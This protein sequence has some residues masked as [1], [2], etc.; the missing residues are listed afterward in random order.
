MCL[1]WNLI[2]LIGDKPLPYY[3]VQI[4]LINSILYRTARVDTLRWKKKHLGE[5]VLWF[6]HFKTNWMNAC[7]DSIGHSSWPDKTMLQTITEHQELLWWQLCRHWRLS[8]RQSH[9]AP[10][11]IKL[12]PS[13]LSGYS[14]LTG[15][16]WQCHAHNGTNRA[17]LKIAQSYNGVNHP[18]GHSGTKTARYRE[19][20]VLFI[21]NTWNRHLIARP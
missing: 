8:S 10:V 11:A 20:V 7:Y 1:S 3:S 12:V 19:N 16:T 9:V 2:Y 6:Y 21:T 4:K 17:T 15:S 18:E 5:R 14:G 13:Q